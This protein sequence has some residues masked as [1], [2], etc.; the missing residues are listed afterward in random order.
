MLERLIVNPAS[1]LVVECFIAVIAGV[2]AGAAYQR[3]RIGASGFAMSP[4]TPPEL[5]AIF[6]SSAKTV[7]E[8][9][10]I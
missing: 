4:V 3:V 5:R 10:N 1:T 9:L 6:Y 7:A 2:F 8:Q